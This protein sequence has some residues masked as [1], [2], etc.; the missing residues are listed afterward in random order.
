M[1]QLSSGAIFQNQLPSS[2]FPLTVLTHCYR[3]VY[4]PFIQPPPIPL[5]SMT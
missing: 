2:L 5:L 4:K 3:L 1:L